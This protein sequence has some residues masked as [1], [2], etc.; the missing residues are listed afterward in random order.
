MSP[1][2]TASP[3]WLSL[4]EAA[5]WLG[6]HPTTL[7]RWADAGQIPALLTPGGHR[8]FVVAELEHFAREHRLHTT[9][10]VEQRWAEQA[11]DRTRAQIASHAGAHWLQPADEQARETQRVLGRRLLELVTAYLAA[12]DDADDQALEPAQAI[13]REYAD[14]LRGA[15]LAVTDAL[16]GFLFFRDGLVDVALQLPDVARQHAGQR[17][18]LLRRINTVLNT[19]Q[20]AMIDRYAELARVAGEQPTTP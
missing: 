4:A 17:L 2:P 6:V 7:R 13:G 14:I 11:L 16:E 9:S 12:P 15:G 1:T 5:E 19:V 18:R 8:R 3:K 10:G 20:L